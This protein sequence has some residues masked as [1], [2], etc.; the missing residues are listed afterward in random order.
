MS[1]MRRLLLPVVALVFA[2][3]LSVRPAH[4]VGDLQINVPGQATNQVTLQVTDDQ[5][6]TVKEDNDSDRA[7]GIWWFRGKRPGTYTVRTVGANGAIIG[8]PQTVQVRDGQVARLRI[9]PATGMAQNLTRP[10]GGI[11]SGFSVGLLGGAKHTPWDG[12]V[13][14]RVANTTPGSGDFSEWVGEGGLE[15]RYYFTPY[16]GLQLFLMGSYIHY[17][18]SPLEK[19]LAD[20]HPTGGLDTGLGVKERNSMLF[21][22]GTNLNIL[23]R[24]GIGLMTGLHVTTS[25]F[26]V[27]ANETGGNQPNN[28]LTTYKT[29]IG[30][31]VGA[32]LF[33]AMYC[34][35]M[36][37][38]LFL[39]STMRWMPDTQFDR[40]TAVTTYRAQFDG[41]P[42]YD[43]MTGFRIPLNR[44][45]PNF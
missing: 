38:E 7:A 4:A 20:D 18:G 15:G 5:G 28:D 11:N 34:F 24:V 1:Y 9:D 27:L 6:Q 44:I 30:P 41:G 29:Q 14:S 35:G 36:P 23:Q 16:Q 8:Q 32:E 2:A 12:T 10:S 22:V 33:Y 39:R 17:F 43:V 3:G 31:F 13:S 42:N 26:E 45:I 25:R 19:F 40:T 21:G 37:V